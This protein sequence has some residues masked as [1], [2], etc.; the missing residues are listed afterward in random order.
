[1]HIEE[2]YGWGIV[3]YGT[4]CGRGCTL[5]VLAL[6]VR[7]LTIMVVAYVT[8]GIVPYGLT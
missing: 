8:I 3:E 6:V 7:Y 4:I 1:V 2:V 5:E